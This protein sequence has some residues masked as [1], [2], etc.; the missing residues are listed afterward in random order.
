[1]GHTVIYIQFIDHLGWIKFNRVGIVYIVIIDASLAAQS[2]NKTGKT[3]PNLV[4]TSSSYRSRC[5]VYHAS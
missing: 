4:Y 2:F 1:M 3:K 5:L